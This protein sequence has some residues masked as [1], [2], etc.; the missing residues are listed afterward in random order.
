MQQ[1]SAN[2]NKELKRAFKRKHPFVIKDSEVNL[3]GVDIDFLRKHFSDYQT[4]TF[5]PDCVSE[6]MHLGKMIDKVL[7]GGKYRLRS[8]PGLGKKLRRFFNQDF[9]DKLRLNQSSMLDHLLWLGGK[10]HT[11]FLSTPGCEMT[12][13]CHITSGFIMQVDGK[14]TWYISN[15][16][17]FETKFRRLYPYVY[18]TEKNKKREFKVVLEPGD[19]LYIP[20]YWFHYTES[21]EVNFSYNFFFG[22]KAW[23]Y[24][25]GF[26]RPFFLYDLLTKQLGLLQLVLSPA[27]EYGFGDK[28]LWEKTKTAAELEFLQRCDYS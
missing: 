6:T 1:I 3:E 25:R 12:K 21:D 8:E 9:L 28:P 7:R 4:H 13:H 5:N 20:S 14:K 2:N 11:V 23:V 10:N 16:S 17:F 27:I 22:E 24:L 19:L 15:E 26:R 18:L